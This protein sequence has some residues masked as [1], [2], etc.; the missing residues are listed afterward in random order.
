MLDD[1]DFERPKNEIFTDCTLDGIKNKEG[2][3]TKN[4]E[5]INVSSISGTFT[6]S[7][8]EFSK[9]I[10]RSLADGSVVEFLDEYTADGSTKIMMM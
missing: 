2:E 10:D 5:V 7:E 3:F 4:F 1:F 9:E 6:W 8:K